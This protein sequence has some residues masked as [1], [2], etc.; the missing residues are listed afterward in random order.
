[1]PSLVIYNNV[2]RGA[3]FKH[4]KPEI[5]TKTKKGLVKKQGLLKELKSLLPMNHQL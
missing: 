5:N 2:L 3:T 4:K 1:V